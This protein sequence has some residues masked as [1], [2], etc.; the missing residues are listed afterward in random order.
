MITLSPG[1]LVSHAA[2]QTY[3][4][5]FSDSQWKNQSGDFACS[6]THE[7]PGFGSARLARKAGS[8]EVLELNAKSQGLGSD[9][10]KVEAVA[11]PW[12]SDV[13]PRT[14]GQAQA[15]NQSLNVS[16]TQIGA[17][18]SALE[19]GTNV[20]FSGSTLR[21]G[22]AA[23][24]FGPA[25]AIYQ[26]CVKNLIPYTFQQLSHTV[27][28]YDVDADELSSRSKTGLDKIVRYVKAD[29]QVLGLIVDA[30]SDKL[31][32]PEQGDA[33]SKREAEWVTAYLVEKGI[34]AEQITTRWHG[35]K[36][37]IAD[38]KTKAGQA[39][40]RRVT[41]RLENAE[42]RKEMEKK[43]AAIKA[44]EEQ[45]AAEKATSSAAEKSVP[46][47]DAKQLQDLTE[48]QNILNGKQ[49][50]VGLPR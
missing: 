8:G 4:A 16:G 33:L 12:R 6:L 25:F 35:D 39:K 5:P 48:Q 1:F 18:T 10:F 42:T 2:A 13:T 11:P 7:I 27:L 23:R 47:I 24:N 50:E 49:P 26:K 43:V 9:A 20:I 3:I 15:N 22:L 30:H 28:S 36:F 21:A 34:P 46:A 17:I 32:K 40:N 45:A 19:Q 44:A 41:V 14:L 37:P 31:P 29:K 38:N